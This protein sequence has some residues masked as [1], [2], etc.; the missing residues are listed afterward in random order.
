MYFWPEQLLKN[1][2]FCYLDQGLNPKIK[3]IEFLSFVGTMQI[4][5]QRQ[6]CNICETLANFS[7][8]ICHLGRVRPTLSVTFFFFAD[9]FSQK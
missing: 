8:I 5:N 7:E 9:F 3:E 2:L 4:E 6:P 1:G